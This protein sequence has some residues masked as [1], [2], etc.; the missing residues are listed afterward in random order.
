MK[1]IL[2]ITGIVLVVLIGLLAVIPLFFK[3]TLIDK[4][5]TTINR[6]VNATVEFADLKLSL[7]RNFPNLTVN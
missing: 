6:N 2:I 5:K 1:K 7:L 3:Q 4:T